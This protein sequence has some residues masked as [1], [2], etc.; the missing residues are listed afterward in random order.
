MRPRYGSGA[1]GPVI[2]R[3]MTVLKGRGG[4]RGRAR[5]ETSEEDP[6]R[7]GTPADA[8]MMLF[9]GMTNGGVIGT[10]YRLA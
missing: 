6:A 9:I 3:K 4:G 2:A 10:R 7:D 5:G 8:G 1:C